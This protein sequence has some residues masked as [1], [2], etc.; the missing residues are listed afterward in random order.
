VAKKMDNP[1]NYLVLEEINVMSSVN[2]AAN[3]QPQR[4]LGCLIDHSGAPAQAVC[5]LK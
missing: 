1:L 4:K 3:Q 5:L 2:Y